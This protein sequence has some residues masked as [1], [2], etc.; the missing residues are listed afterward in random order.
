MSS[1][2]LKRLLSVP[3]PTGACESDASCL[4]KRSAHAA[5]GVFASNKMWMLW[6]R[7]HIDGLRRHGSRPRRL[8]W[9]CDSDMSVEAS[10]RRWWL[11]TVVVYVLPVLIDPVTKLSLSLALDLHS[12]V[13]LG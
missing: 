5:S 2:A 3:H 11:P 1:V 8:D 12:R 13:L 6:P 4:V 7:Q 10:R 9:S